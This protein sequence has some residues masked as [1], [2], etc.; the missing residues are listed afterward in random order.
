MYLHKCY[1]YIAAYIIILKL[2]IDLQIVDYN[3]KEIKAVLETESETRDIKQYVIKVV[4][5]R[6]KV[7]KNLEYAKKPKNLVMMYCIIMV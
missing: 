4:L 6:V 2:R 5:K 3:I 1:I 7:Y